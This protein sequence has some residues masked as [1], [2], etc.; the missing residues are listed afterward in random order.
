[1]I[2]NWRMICTHSLATCEPTAS[3]FTMIAPQRLKRSPPS[4]P[5]ELVKAPAADF[6][7]IGEVGGQDNH[8]IAVNHHSAPSRRERRSSIHRSSA[9]QIYKRCQKVEAMKLRYL[10]LV[11]AL[12]G[13][14]LPY[15]QFLPWIMDHHGLNISLFVHDMFANQISAFFTIDVIVSAIVL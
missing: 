2:N 15:S 10:Y 12:I 3:C 9:R 7:F 11:L 13:L 1:M 5:N 8:G 4:K 14:I 6:R